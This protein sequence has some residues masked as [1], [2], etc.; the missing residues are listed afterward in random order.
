MLLLGL[1][2]F[3]KLIINL[4]DTYCVSNCDY[5]TSSSGRYI[6]CALFLEV[7]VSLNTIASSDLKMSMFY[8]FG[9][10]LYSLGCSYCIQKSVEALVDSE[11]DKVIRKAHQE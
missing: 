1:L 9:D 10:G 8:H 3:N 5:E 11:L 6:V 4:T 7:A 2:H